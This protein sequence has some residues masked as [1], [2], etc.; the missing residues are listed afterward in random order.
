MDAIKWYLFYSASII[1]RC[2]QGNSK[3]ESSPSTN[4]IIKGDSLREKGRIRDKMKNY[5]H[6]PFSS[7]K[8]NIV[9]LVRISFFASPLAHVTTSPS[10]LNWSRI[11]WASKTSAIRNCSRSPTRCF[12]GRTMTECIWHVIELRRKQRQQQ[13][14]MSRVNVDI[15]IAKLF[16][17]QFL[18][19]GQVFLFILLIAKHAM[20]NLQML[21]KSS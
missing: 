19:S 16:L 1:F 10:Q 8:F 15:F 12:N 3:I 14:E 4:R 2:L 11:K 7:P 5:F 9:F 21:V 20:C 17:I 6:F 18:C 13:V